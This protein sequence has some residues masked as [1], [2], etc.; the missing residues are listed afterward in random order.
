MSQSIA[1]P[2]AHERVWSKPHRELYTKLTR[3]VKKWFG[4]RF[5]IAEQLAKVRDMEL[6]GV[7]KYRSFEDYIQKEI[8]WSRQRV[9]QLIEA[10][11]TKK[12]LPA[13]V[14]GDVDSVRTASALSKIPEHERADAVRE[15]KKSGKVTG[16]SIKEAHQKN[17]KSN[18]VDTD[19][20]PVDKLGFP[21]PQPIWN[22][23]AIASTVSK[24][25]LQRVSDLKKEIERGIT[26]GDVP[27]REL[28][29]ASIGQLEAVYASLK[30]MVPYAVCT[31]CSGFN[32]KTC[33]LCAQKGFLSEYRW[34]MVPS[35]TR[36]MRE[37]A[38]KK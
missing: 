11:E 25:L 24:D 21:V 36:A 37:K 31:S 22:D 35:E 18:A 26:E 5:K 3:N 23:W 32:R 17:R 2:Q 13:D 30:A 29:N 34:K 6:Y 19:E 28:T 14:A 8:G 4:D 1:P 27:F 7:G 38:G 33:K 9:Y 15:A 12:A 10:F 16:E 20:G